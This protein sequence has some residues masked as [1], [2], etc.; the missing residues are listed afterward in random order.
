V[1]CVVRDLLECG[2]TISAARQVDRKARHGRREVRL[3]WALRDPDLT[4]YLGW[5]HLEQVCRVERRRALVHQ[6]QVV[7]TEVEIS[8]AITSAP[9]ARADAARLLHALRGHWGIENKVHHVRD[10]TFDEDR[11][12]IRTAAAPQVFAACRNLATA[13]LRRLGYDNIAA[14]LRTYAARPEAAIHLVV[15][16]GKN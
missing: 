13:L 5:P 2:G 16:G 14:A 8:Y 1:P 10:V 6:G 3:L 4:R 12:Q 11:S 9:P 15:S 7:K